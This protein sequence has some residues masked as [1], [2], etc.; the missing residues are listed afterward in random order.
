MFEKY[1]N[2]YYKGRIKQAEICKLENIY[3]HKLYKIMNEEGYKPYQKVFDGIDT[4]IKELNRLLRNRYSDIVGRCNGTYGDKYGH[5]NGLEYISNIEWVEFC[6]LNKDKLVEIWYKYIINK[7]LKYAV[8]IDRIEDSKGYILGNLD[9]VSHGFNSW[10][11]T[12]LRPIKVI[13]LQDNEEYYFMSCAEGSDYFNIREQ[14]LSEILRNTLYHDKNFLV[15]VSTIECV[16]K[17]KNCK[18]IKEYY[19]RYYEEVIK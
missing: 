10:K 3:S 17:N 2:D 18:N 14:V 5:Y 19:L 8:S 11:R 6:N 12:L 7:D 16:L 1:A 13:D 15:E 9:F 4:G